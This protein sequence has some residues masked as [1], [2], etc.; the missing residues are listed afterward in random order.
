M[1]AG[2]HGRRGH[3]WHGPSTSRSAQ[4]GL[5]RQVCS[6]ASPLP[7]PRPRTQ[8]FPRFPVTTPGSAKTPIPLLNGLSTQGSFTAT[9]R[10]LL[11]R[12]RTPGG[13]KPSTIRGLQHGFA[14][15]LEL[16]GSQGRSTPRRETSPYWPSPATSVRPTRRVTMLGVVGTPST[17]AGRRGTSLT[18]QGLSP[19]SDGAVR[20]GRPALPVIYPGSRRCRHEDSHR[21]SQPACPC[22]ERPRYGTDLAVHS[23][24]LPNDIYPEGVVT[25][26]LLG[27]TAGVDV[28]RIW[29]D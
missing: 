13:V 1:A 18:T 4:A 9:R 10:W 15:A 12:G 16:F 5:A 11:R 7:S 17:H 21:D 8:G 24:R 6:L 25:F 29:A 20:P 22:P 28:L 14:L 2:G 23:D 27:A 26:S 3:Q 19:A